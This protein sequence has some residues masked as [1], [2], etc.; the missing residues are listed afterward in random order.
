M[1]IWST[2]ASKRPLATPGTIDGNFTSS[3]S[4]RNPSFSAS[5]F[6]SRISIPSG[7][8]AADT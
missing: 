4:G 3:I 6:I 8:P 7:A 5:S 1:L 2:P